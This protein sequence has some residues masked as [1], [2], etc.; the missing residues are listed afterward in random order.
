VIALTVAGVVLKIDF[1]KAFEF[2]NTKLANNGKFAALDQGVISLSN[3]AASILLVRWVSPTK[4]GAYVTGFLAIYFV[5]AIQNGLVIQPLNA[6][7]AAKSDEDFKRYFSA[8][9]VHQFILAVLSA[10][11]AA[12]LGWILTIRGNNILGPTIFVL[13]F[14]FFTWQLQEYF[15][16]A[17]YTRGEV[18]KAFWI[19][20]AGNSLRLVLM[21]VLAQVG[22]ISGL[23]GLTAIGWGAFLGVLVGAWFAR[24]YF[25]RQMDPPLALW[26]K[27]WRFGRWIL[28]ASLADWVVVDLYPILMAGL[29]SFAATG[30]Y[31]TLQNLVAPIHVLL[32]AMD[33]FVTPIMAR[34]YDQQGT[35]K[36]S[37]NLKHIYL[38]AGVPVIGLLILVLIFTPQLLKLLSGNTY[39]PY[40]DGIY[41]MALYYLFLYVNRPLQMAFRAIRQGRQIFIANIVAMVSMFT[42]GLWMIH[43]WGLYGA[44][45]GQALNAII[46]SLVLILAWARFRRSGEN[47]LAE[48]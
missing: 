21:I 3:F 47:G 48:D 24:G 36:L 42:L 12:V 26:L 18:H 4:V 1:R 29:I 23:T 25:T 6:E 15:R 31:Q 35:K 10:V 41:V 28:G 8:A 33:T 45:G 9:F 20:L 32:R 46:I 27:N 43:T 37:Q 40:A 16:R 44:I 22:E 30:V 11:G 17:F 38:I 5:R 34:T 13:W 19:S 39:L 14:A 7:G 2:M